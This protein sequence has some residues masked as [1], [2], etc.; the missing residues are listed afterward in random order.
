M[1][2]CEKCGSPQVMVGNDILRKLESGIKSGFHQFSLGNEMTAIDDTEL[3]RLRAIE[4]M[5]EGFGKF[6]VLE[7]AEGEQ[8]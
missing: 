1:K 2:Y 6:F 7:Q 3:K 8:A 5:A 4:R